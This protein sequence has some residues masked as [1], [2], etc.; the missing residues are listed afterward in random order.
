[1]V[2]RLL[3]TVAL[4]AAAP[5]TAGT[6]G[7]GTAAPAPREIRVREGGSHRLSRF[8]T[9][10]VEVTRYRGFGE[11]SAIERYD[12]ATVLVAERGRD[13]LSALSLDGRLAWTIPAKEPRSVQVIAPDRFLVAEASPPAVVELDRSGAVR[14]RSPVLV[15]PRGALRLPDGNTAVVESSGANAVR[16]LSPGG[17]PLWTA[18]LQQPRGLAR[19]PGGQLVTSGLDT[20]RVV[21]F[22]PYTERSNFFGACCHVEVAGATPQ[23]ELIVISA[24]S[25]TVEA[26]SVGGSRHWRFET[27]YPPVAAAA[28]SD[29][30]VLVALFEVPDRV[31]NNAYRASRPWALPWSLRWPLIGIAAASMVSWIVRRASPRAPAV[32]LKESPG[33]VAEVSAQAASRVQIGACV[34][35]VLG[36]AAVAAIFHPK[37]LVPGQSR[38]ALYLPV[39]I[40]GGACLARLQYLAGKSD[41]RWEHS[42]HRLRAMLP[43]GKAALAL[44]SLGV[45]LLATSLIGVWRQWGE[46][47]IA[48]WAAALALL[49]GGAIG[50]G[51]KRPPLR[52]FRALALVALFAGLATIR[53]L[54]LETCPPNLHHDMGL[55]TVN[56]LQLVDGEHRS[57]LGHGYAEVPLIGHLWSAFWTELFG[58]SLAAARM[59]SVLASL[60]AIAALYA[61]SGRFFGTWV[62][63]VAALLLGVEHE[64]LHYSRIQAY[65]DPVLFQALAALGLLRGLE[66]G[67]Y[68]WF[69]L[70]GFSG[71]YS[72]LSYHS[73]RITPLLLPVLAAVSLV[74]RPRLLAARWR[75]LV[76]ALV[77]GAAMLAPQAILYRTARANPFGRSDV[78]PF[79]VHDRIDREALQ[80]TIFRGVP[81]IIGGFWIYSDNASQYGHSGP[82]L[83]PLLAALLGMSVVAALLRPGDER[84]VLLVV[85]AAMVLFLG[86]VLTIDPPFWPRMVASLLPAAALIGASLGALRFGL[87]SLSPRVGVAV[88]TVA[89]VGL[90]G[91]TA[92]GQLDLY[93]AFCGHDNESVQS[94]MG[95]D[96]QR[97]SPEDQVFIVSAKPIDHSCAHPTMQYYAYERDVRD[98]REIDRY[99][100]FAA[101]RVICYVLPDRQE[102][103]AVLHRWYP[104]AAE[105]RFERSGGALLFT[106]LVVEPDRRAQGPLR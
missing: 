7:T 40:L 80:A 1:M 49:I 100:P 8:T 39:V 30:T 75:G 21:A 63:V 50:R 64:F 59:A 11:V 99:L 2:L 10:G 57:L 29:G 46:W 5:A 71:G 38:L 32:P 28:L 51:G 95:R 104:K 74:R 15:D 89:A 97:S 84:G 105:K 72:A 17:E 82:A 56:A 101:R 18:D 94:V 37:W 66:A 22:D 62:A 61:L 103:L 6:S 90:L 77:I 73:G 33:A 9:E 86:G 93:R 48:G 35:G 19:L 24:E 27:L 60:V 85:W 20:G 47:V 70:A 78:F 42:M 41:N 13:E 96:I 88:A 79:V 106:R 53:I 34:A 76:F 36:C 67:T 65:M 14:W 69:Y 43:P 102:T 45:L 58:R 16:V 87:A 98:A 92:R 91:A 23:G 3:V 12:D 55:W 52:P 4:I 54:H 81:R 31:C 26:Y 83:P 25:Q 68:G 44:W